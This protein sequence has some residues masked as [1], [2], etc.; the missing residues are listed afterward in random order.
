MHVSDRYAAIMLQTAA[1]VCPC[2]CLSSAS[3]IAACGSDV[4]K[5]VTMDDVIDYHQV[6]PGSKTTHF[7]NFHKDSGI[8]YTDMVCSSSVSNLLT[9]FFR[10]PINVKP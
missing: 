1:C 2:C 3:L 10:I 7:K 4:H 6:F 5:G 9:L 8:D